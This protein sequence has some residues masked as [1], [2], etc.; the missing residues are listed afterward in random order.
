MSAP[1]FQQVEAL[2]PSPR[3]LGCAAV[4]LLA[5]GIPLFT[6]LGITGGLV[7]YG[8]AWAF[9][10]PSIGVSISA[11]LIAL[12]IVALAIPLG[13]AFGF[14]LFIPTDEHPLLG[15]AFALAVPALSVIF[16]SS[17]LLFFAVP[18]GIGAGLMFH[19]C[20]P[21][22]ASILLA[23][24]SPLAGL[25]LGVLMAYPANDDGNWGPDRGPIHNG[26]GGVDLGGDGGADGGGDGGGE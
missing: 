1:S 7:S 16:R 12:I 19:W 25:A 17:E 22:W 10:T 18:A 24:L 6:V 11:G 9:G 13:L 3:R 21:L 20:Q 4:V 15:T 8:L 26:D 5:L 2:P 14:L 23:V